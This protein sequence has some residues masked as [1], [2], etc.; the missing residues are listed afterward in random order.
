MP[1]TLGLAI[2]PGIEFP[3]DSKL[4]VKWDDG[5]DPVT[6]RLDATLDPTVARRIVDGTQF[7]L[8]RATTLPGPMTKSPKL[9]IDATVGHSKPISL[10]AKDIPIDGSGLMFLVLPLPDRDK[11]LFAGHVVHPRQHFNTCQVTCLGSGKTAG[12]GK[13][14]EC[15][16]DVA[17]V[18]LCC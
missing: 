18:E 10:Q 7:R 4:V 13:C 12:P 1:L 3:S 5:S 17:I 15:E 14:I 6:L 2:D 8:R 11:I 16:N 9:L